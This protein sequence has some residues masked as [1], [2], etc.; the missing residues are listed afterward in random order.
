MP[1][2]IIEDIA[3]QSVYLGI[4]EVCITG[5]EPL[6]Y[7][8]IQKTVELFTSKG[9]FVSIVSNGYLFRESF[10]PI[11]DKINTR[12]LSICFSLDGARPETH[13][14]LRR[15]EGSF[16]KV[17]DAIKLC[18]ESGISVSLKMALWKGNINEI[19]DMAVLGR[20]YAEQVSFIIL[21]PTPELI[22]K[23][24]IPSPKEYQNVIRKIKREIMPIFP[25]IEIEGICERDVPVPLCN[26]FFSGPNIDYLGEVSF[27]CNLSNTIGLN[28]KAVYIGDIK[29]EKL[30][31]IF[32]KHMIKCSEYIK[33]MVK[34][35]FSFW[36][37]T[38]S[39]C[40]KIFGQM[41]W[42]KKVDSPWRNIL[43]KSQQL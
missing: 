34:K 23:D 27:C 40:M 42:L 16:E 32:Y 36:E 10:F 28:K 31:E 3:E 4:K 7:P 14:F 18:N 17:I 1:Y 25:G 12:L 6:L 9:I 19:F 41:N 26:P 39:Y 11:L 2:E 8:E 15:K 30:E 38:C 35:P 21:S 22:K 13:D 43:W 24:L 37:R 20:T 5:G 33:F 29:K